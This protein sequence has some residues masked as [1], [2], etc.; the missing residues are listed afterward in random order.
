M[1]IVLR[2]ESINFS[3]SVWTKDINHPQAVLKKTIASRGL[4]EQATFLKFN[5]PLALETITPISTQ[6]DLAL[7]I[8]QYSLPSPIFFEN[9][10]YE[11]DFE[12]KSTLSEPPAVLHR[13]SKIQDSFHYTGRSV[14]GSLNFGNDIGWF[15]LGLR[16][17]EGLTQTTQYIS[18]Q[19]LPTK[20]AMENDLAEIHK[21]IDKEYPLWRFSFVQKTEQ[22]LANSSKPHEQ[23]ELLWL[24]HFSALRSQLETG[25]KYICSFPH[26]RLL[27]YERNLKADRIRGRISNGLEERVFEDLKQGAIEKLYRIKKQRLS[28]DTPENRFIKMVLI[29]CT[30]VISLFIERARQS[31]KIPDKG[32]LSPSFFEE[33]EGWSKPLDHL[34]KR[35][36]F[37]EIGDFEGLTRESLVLQQR[38]GYAKVYHIWQELKQY[39]DIF[40]N[41]ASISMKSVADLYEIWCLLEIKN[42]L[43]ELGF[44]VISSAKSEL[45]DNG[46]EK[47]MTSGLTAAFHLKRE[48][49]ISIRLAHE[50]LFKI[51]D[52]VK[53]GKIYS[54]TTV[55]KPDILLEATFPNSET[56]HWIF[57]AKY[58]ISGE[59]DGD[60]LIPD[61]AINQMHR[62]RDSI[63]YIN[64]ID[65]I[66]TEKCRPIIGA[67][68]LYPG[69]FNEAEEINPY[70]KMIETVGIGGFPFLPCQPNSWLKKFLVENLGV[71]SSN[72]SHLLPSPDF[73]FEKDPLKI[74]PKGTK[75][76]RI[77]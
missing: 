61:D 77:K 33:L 32:R 72:S 22:E 65:S 66:H 1:P 54:Y 5:P 70:S 69:W 60:D 12:F 24:A 29:K 26:A 64:K 73:Y 47:V 27:S 16:F 59:E 34:L 6:G 14:R 50:P 18:F 40:G 23:F 67:Y 45:L 30:K 9:K 20:M 56:I 71:S 39:L 11:F 28:V 3:L 74:P 36:F 63:L 8:S 7:P 19:V 43:E 41:N 52:V 55:Q 58:R 68:V 62:Y 51:A 38:T 42:I 57:D 44:E 4:D 53:L 75:L 76:T 17:N 37:S 46:V 25:A 15:R 21:V 49:G 2:L 35:P 13:L 31:E 48:D 10:L